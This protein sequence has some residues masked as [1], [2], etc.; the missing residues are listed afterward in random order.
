MNAV[1][2][3]SGGGHVA[4]DWPRKGETA[5]REKIS[6]VKLVPGWNWVVGTG[7]YVDDV[8][9]AVA[10]MRANTDARIEAALLRLVGT[11][12]LVTLCA[13][14]VALVMGRWLRRRVGLVVERLRDIA[15]GDGDLTQRIEVTSQDSLGELAEWFNT[16]VSRIQT[17]LRSVADSSTPLRAS[18]QSLNS[19]SDA[20]SGTTEQIRGESGG[21]VSAMQGMRDRLRSVASAADGAARGVSGVAA[22]NEEMSS[23][24]QTLTGSVD[25]LSANLNSI[26]SATEEMNLSLSEVS[27]RCAE[28]ASAS[29]QSSEIA[30]EANSRMAT[31]FEAAKRIGKVVQLIEDIA[32]QTNLLALNATIEAARAGDAGKGFAVVANEVKELAK[33]SAKATESI[34]RKISSML[35]DTDAAMIKIREVSERSKEVNNLASMIAAAVEEQSATTRGIADHVQ[36]SADRAHSPPPR[37]GCA[38]WRPSCPTWWR[39][40]R[41]SVVSGPMPDPR[42]QEHATDL[43]VIGFGLALLLLFTPLRELWARDHAP[44][45]APFAIWAGLV[46]LGAWLIRQ[47]TRHG[48]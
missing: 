48:D 37:P 29:Q 47:W 41:S 22:A 33:E 16:F 32:E 34:S 40:S 20:L 27:Q 25:A 15:E 42:G 18:V 2:A 24:A 7:V 9:T 14:L 35:Q 8:D 17:M 3:E 43:V 21:V 30:Q 39:A 45:W 12:A 28:S 36:Q 23:N 6:Y 11:V 10:A 13:V 31:L 46:A 26:V 1:V 5:Y 44:W 19:I 38:R 4:Y